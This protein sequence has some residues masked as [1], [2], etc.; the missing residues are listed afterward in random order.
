MIP[1]SLEVSPTSAPSGRMALPF[2]I[3][4]RLRVLTG[5]M[6]FA[7]PGW[8]WTAHGHRLITQAS[9]ESLERIDL[10]LE[11]LARAAIVEAAVQP[12]LMRP[13]ELPELRRIEA[14]RHFIDLELLQGADLP[15]EL[16][17]Y[18]RLLVHL[19][20]SEQGLGGRE[21]DFTAVGMV[22]YAVIE[23]THRLA[24]VFAQLRARPG[25]EI[26]SSMAFSLA[27]QVAHYAQD[28]CQPLHTTVHHDGRA[29][30]DGSSPHIGIHRAVD[31]LLGL[32]ELPAARATG[33]KP[34]QRA[35]LLR[36]VLQELSDSHAL[37]DTVYEL[38]QD[39][40]AAYETGKIS[41]RLEELA[42]ERYLRA[43]ALT[44]DL[45]YTAWVESA[46][47]KLASWAT[48]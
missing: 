44:A 32:I 38:T 30:G 23:S 31:D 16:Y 9:V 35:E 13:G 2:A 25:D 4:L 34:R 19:S 7:T 8:A 36:E 46:A 1:V 28:L 5:L 48:E 37:V 26:L 42:R 18:Q 41:S 3:R 10:P 11:G 15:A 24:A 33:R 17:Q 21:D 20:E 12:D 29:R 27:G 40:E 45:I 6:V 14:P 22:P 43:T 47:I 39:L